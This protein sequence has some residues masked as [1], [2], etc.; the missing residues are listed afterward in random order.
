MAANQ[1]SWAQLRQQARAQET[2]TESLFHTYAQYASK[3]DLE[4]QPSEEEKRTEEQLNEILEKV[5]RAIRP[6]EQALQNSP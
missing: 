1:S 4:A 3:T 5:S 6:R 2:Q